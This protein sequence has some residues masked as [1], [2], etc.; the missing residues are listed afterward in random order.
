VAKAN[1]TTRPI[2]LP[3]IR[4]RW[5]DVTVQGITPFL[6]HRFSPEA[7]EEMEGKKEKRAKGTR[8]AKDPKALYLQSLYPVPGAANSVYGIPAVAF[9]QSMVRA[10]RHKADRSMAEMKGIIFVEGYIL[11]IRDSKPEMDSRIARI[12]GTADLRHRGV[13]RGPW[14]VDLSIRI[15][16]DTVSPEEVLE[17]L[18]LAG[19]L[20]GVGDYR[21]EKAGEF[22]RFEIIGSPELREE[23]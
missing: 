23:I 18:A 9:K 22:G 10:C 6:S 12:R 17:L 20:V 1:Q 11:P 15:I 7:I 8:K 13:F 14:K 19:E 3:K 2:I 5:L 4:K 16:A 21:P